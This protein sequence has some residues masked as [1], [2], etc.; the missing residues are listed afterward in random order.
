MKLLSN[1]FALSVVAL[2]LGFVSCSDNDGELSIGSQSLNIIDGNNFDADGH[3]YTLRIS[4][5][6]FDAADSV[7][8]LS[9]NAEW[10]KLDVDVLPAS[11]MFDVL[12]Q[13][14]TSTASRT[15]TIVATSATNPRH[16]ASVEVTQRGV[17]DGN[18]A[19][20]D[21]LVN[22]RLGYGFSVFEEYKNINSVKARIIDE[23]LIKQYEDESTYSIIQED[24][25]GSERM[26]Y[27]AAYSLCD[28]QSQMTEKSTSSTSFLGFKK[29][30]SR[31]QK[32]STHSLNEQ[33]YGYAR[34]S[35]IVASRNM[36][37]GALMH[38]MSRQDLIKDKKLPFT[39]E[40]YTT[41]TAIV[42][43][44]N[45]SK[46]ATLIDK[47][48][49][50]FGTHLIIRAS[51]G[52]S[53]DYVF[54]LDRNLYTSLETAVEKE[55]SSMFG[56][57]SSSES[58]TARNVV[59]S[60]KN[61]DGAFNLIGGEPGVVSRMKGEFAKMDSTSKL[62]NNDVKAW[63]SSVKYEDLDTEQG[64]KNL[65]VVD[66]QFMPVW[67]LFDNQTISKEILAAVTRLAETE[68]GMFT[69]DELKIDNYEI[70]ISE[71]RFQNFGTDHN[72]TLVKVVYQS[73]VPI[74]EICNEYV[75]SIRSDKRVNVYYPIVNG[76]TQLSQG[77]FPGDGEGNPPAYLS[78][79]DGSVY[80]NPIDGFS[81]NDV[82]KKVYYLHGSLYTSNYGITPKKVTL[83]VKDHKLKLSGSSKEYAV[84]KLGS[85]YWTRSCIQENMRFGFY[86][87]ATP[88]RP[89]SITISEETINGFLYART[90][91]TNERQ[92]MGV[93]ADVYSFK[94]NYQLGGRTHWY[95]PASTERINLT[96]YVGNNHK[97]LL[98]GQVSGFDAEFLGTFAWYD[99]MNTSKTYDV[100]TLIYNGDYCFVAF[101]D[102]TKADFSYEITGGSVLAIGKD[103]EWHVITEYPGEG[104]NVKKNWYPVKLFRT[105]CFQY[106]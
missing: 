90:D 64:R 80:V 40:F 27:F 86:K 100:K 36:D 104:F 18:S 57:G 9:C 35:K 93:N 79:K 52:G 62:S 45:A 55:A 70:N 24:R 47:M 72:S 94:Y 3:Y 103:Y 19:A 97:S 76:R 56:R 33:Y 14:N 54:T 53:L 75:P 61:A 105:A 63:L 6:G 106:K 16:T 65:G 15:A 37:Q 83:S 39:K 66:F 17:G 30:A 29:T 34:L 60:R 22:F 31:I 1:L 69:D 73:D 23:A 78:F 5:E 81:Y 48:I 98:M 58:S 41:Y 51:A 84:V 85:G 28:I 89:G 96:N 50:Q 4:S 20:E 68:K 95:L 42:T 26:E 38:L 12:A 8:L 59:L 44:A 32:V 25:R 87:N 10:L 74:L 46:R 102:I 91:G 13:A 11:G 71:T 92:F 43:E 49:E 7:I 2:V 67:E 88:S 77:L 21:V 99:P 101:K 82:V